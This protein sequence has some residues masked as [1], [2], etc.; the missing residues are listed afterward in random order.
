[1]FQVKP[2]EEAAYGALINLW[3]EQGTYFDFWTEPRGLGHPTDVMVPPPF[4]KP[5][6]NFLQSHKIEYRIKIADVQT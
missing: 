4:V 6:E 1:M 5:F 2:Q 3:K